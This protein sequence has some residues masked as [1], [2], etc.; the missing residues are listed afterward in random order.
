MAPHSLNYSQVL[1]QLQVRPETGLDSA[2]A[3]KRL[4]KYGVNKLKAKKNKTSLQRFFEQFKDVMILILILAAVI[5]FAIACH[6][7]EPEG[8]FEPALILLIVVINATIGVIQES[9]AEKA[10]EAL[11]NLSAPHARVIRDG[12]E[13]VIEA[14]HLVPGDIISL[15]AGDYVP[16]DARIILSASLQS[17][18]SAL[19]GE[20]VP[21]EKDAAA[22]V[23]ENAP[24]GDRVNM[25]YSGCSITYGHAKAVVTAT[26]T[27]TEMGKIAHL[28]DS[29]IDTQT[30]LQHK[31][32]Q[33][34]KYL[35]FMA[36]AAC[37]II[38]VIGIM[39]GM[40]AM[41]IFMIAVSLAVSA[42]PE[43]LPAIVTVVLAIGVQRM[44]KKN[45]IIKTLPAVETLGSATV[46]CSDKTGTLT[47]NKMTLVK[48][49]D[50]ETPVL[51]DIS[52]DNS[53]AIKKLLQYA[54]LCCDGT[55]EFENGREHHIG[56]PTET[57]I[58]LAARKNGMP[59]DELNRLYP[60]LAELPFDSD[61]KL[62]T[63]VNHIDGKYI[64]I[65]KGAFDVLADRCIKGNLEAGRKYARELSRQAL[66]LLAVAY[67]EIATLPPTPTTEELES[68]LTFMGLVGMIDPP[69]PEARDAVAVCR[70]AG[71]K[72]VM[73][74]GDHV[75]TASAIAK[76]LGI[77]LDEDDAI[78]GRKLAMMSEAELNERVRNIAVYARV[79]P[80]DKIRIVRAWQH[81]G[82]I[83]SMTGDGV[84]DAPAL[85]AAD[86]GCA[87]GITGTDVAKGASD[88]ILTDD[89]F[90]S[91]V[92]AVRE[93][94][95]IYDN[96][97]KVVGFL[98]GT[99]IGEVLTV[100]IAMLFWRESP[101]LAIQ[102]LW[103]NLITDSLPAIA[104]GMEAVER[105]VMTRKPRPRGE[106]IFAHG[107]GIR[108]VMLGTMFAA[109]TLTGFLIGWKSTGNIVAGRTM[110]FLVLALSQVIH[111]F[112]M[113][114]NHSLFKTGIF[115]NRY[116]NWAAGISV[117]LIGFIVFIPAVATAFGLTQLSNNM[118]LLALGLAMAP[119][120]VLE[121][122]K[123]FGLLKK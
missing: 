107:L 61:R 66:R 58:V 29:A 12:K 7:G 123:A 114:S 80:E 15:E 16:A 10:L 40:N 86:I 55:V 122:S 4:A 68:G 119:V 63:T 5:S 85:K 11:Q 20:S 3:S 116:L 94:R 67:K 30:P 42:I 22:V 28:L 88:I 51:E 101:L 1:D 27:D 19:T 45:V 56:D 36:L 71:I 44:V 90:A 92:D 41:E 37:A 99:N 46:I 6:E 76:D 23:A 2:E 79:S 117:A 43:G 93:G 39:D 78:T 87:M 38:F 26:G 82:E 96:I 103:I 104:L 75:A 108:I 110:A 52:E 35:G 50:A 120:V 59:K 62:M 111:S 13:T 64:V 121:M 48:A 14:A 118:Y 91:I 115:S 18:E 98:L 47:Q 70:Q 31:L 32:A 65:V 73:I 9:K 100:F 102:L 89:N 34:G 97:R 84:N 72:P 17:Q 74:T 57:S 49:L 95:G 21:V 69:R 33:L 77:L 54:A 81:Q 24:L 60:R 105:D 8:F 106:S 112:N 109:L 25:L 83:V 53:P 113:R